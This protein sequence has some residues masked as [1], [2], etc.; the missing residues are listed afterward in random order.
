MPF[1]LAKNQG[2]RLKKKKKKPPEKQRTRYGRE[3]KKRNKKKT[4]GASACLCLRFLVSV[5]CAIFVVSPKNEFRRAGKA[6]ARDNL[7]SA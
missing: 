4:G 3:W 1:G 2:N 6:G 7:S 5:F